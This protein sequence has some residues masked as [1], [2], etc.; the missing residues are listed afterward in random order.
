METLTQQHRLRWSNLKTLQLTFTMW[1]VVLSMATAQSISELEYFFGADPGF[2]NG[3]MI[4][5]N[6]NTG[7]LTQ[8]GNITSGSAIE[9]SAG[10]TNQNVTFL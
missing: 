5:A 7:D 4:S 1:L 6:S 3:T 10:G 2:G 8:V 9:I